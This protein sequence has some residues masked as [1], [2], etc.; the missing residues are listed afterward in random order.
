MSIYHDKQ[1]ALQDAYDT[2]RLADV[3]ES[4][5]LHLTCSTRSTRPSSSAKDFFFLATA[6]SIGKAE[7]LV[8]GRA[9]RVS[10][11]S[12]TSE[13]S[14]SPAMTA[15]ACTSRWGMCWPIRKIGML[16]VD[17]EKPN[18]LRISGEASIAENDSAAGGLSGSPV[19]RP[20]RGDRNLPQLPA[21]H[22]KIQARRGLAV[23]A[24]R[25]QSRRRFRTGSR[26]I[27]CARALPARDRQKSRCRCRPST[28]WITSSSI[29]ES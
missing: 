28:S 13:P 8:Q 1:R 12:S 15:T 11:G 26:S 27:S 6:D 4:N 17:F 10:F 3:I 25:R 7:L 21:L 19:H 23:R 16:F 22:S 29:E 24:G 9:W 20:R 14:P 5:N 18:R 2:R